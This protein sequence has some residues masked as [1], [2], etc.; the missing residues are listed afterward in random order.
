MTKLIYLCSF[1][2]LL[3]LLVCC[4]KETDNSGFV[5]DYD[6]LNSVI[7]TWELR[8]Q[9][10]SFTTTYAKGNGNVL[11]FN[12]PNYERYTN[13]ALTK[14]G[15]FTLVPDT[16][17]QQNVCLVLSNKEYKNRIVFDGKDEARKTFVRIT[18]NKL[19]L[20]SGCFAN[21]SGSGSVYEK[22]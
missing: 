21:D 16:A 18:K 7:G 8:Q 1:F 6:Y 9:S 19:D 14:S 13:G 15:T 20:V 12:G 22:Q 10:G 2:I 11:K 4:K 17:V 3:T 5:E